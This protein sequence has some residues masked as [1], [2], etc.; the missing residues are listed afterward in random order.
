VNHDPTPAGDEYAG[1]PIIDEAER[2]IRA[3]ALPGHEHEIT[4]D[5]ARAVLAWWQHHSELSPREVDAIL[6][7]F[8]ESDA[9]WLSGSMG[10][11]D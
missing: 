7:R 11:D 2:S 8:P 1:N 4:R 5:Q 10:S 9:G 3:F 6:R